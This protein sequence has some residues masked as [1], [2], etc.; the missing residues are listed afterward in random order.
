MKILVTGG[1]GFI[2]SHVSDRLLEAGHS[3][4]CADDLSLGRKTNIAACLGNARFEFVKADVSRPAALRRIF[5]A[6]KFGCVFHLAAN[7]DIQAGIKDPGIDMRRTFA[8]TSALLEA[9]RARGVKQL[10]FA[11]TS[12]VYGEADRPMAEDCGP[13]VPVSHYGAA[14][15]A[16]EAWISSYCANCGIK[17]WI[18][19]FPNVVGARA[20]HGVIFDFVNRL[21]GNPRRLL[22]LGD[23]KQRKPYL[24]VSDVVS[25]MIF[26]WKN[27]K[28]NFNLYNLAGSGATTVDKIA[29][30]TAAAMKL[31]GVK[32]SY[33][34]GARG[35]QGDVPRFDYDTAKLR[36]LGWKAA[37]DSDSAVR[38][39]ACEI[40]G[41]AKHCSR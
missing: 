35:W 13:L 2:G 27:A 17:S 8:T 3:V 7:S 18:V 30:F 9:M 29:R 41:G 19:R 16:S 24:H 15:L 34:G 40:A 26:V 28:E 36:R 14:K 23:G 10:V 12:A 39:A 11:S 1:A 20:T 31:G 4:V 25:G 6:H 37:L 22:I 38:L 33:T 5:A 21:R 32:F